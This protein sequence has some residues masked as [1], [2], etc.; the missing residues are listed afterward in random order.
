[1]F[2]PQWA[3]LTQLSLQSEIYRYH[4][5]EHYSSIRNID[6]PFEGPPEIN[7]R[8]IKQEP[9]RKLTNQDPP[10]SVERAIMKSTGVDDLAL[11]REL[12]EKYRGDVDSVYNEIYEKQYPEDANAEDGNT[13]RKEEAGVGDV[14]GLQ[15]KSSNQDNDSETPVLGDGKDVKIVSRKGTPIPSTSNNNNT[16]PVPSESTD[17]QKEAGS[18][19]DAE[20]ASAS[21]GVKGVIP[22]K[23]ISAREKKEAA[24]RNQ[25][26]NRKNKGKTNSSSGESNSSSDKLPST[27]SGGSDG[28]GAANTNTTSSTM[29]ELFV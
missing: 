7:P 24:K 21:E 1:M 25:K 8:P 16:D 11:V 14:E 13:E 27:L 20:P 2:K 9:L 18:P 3:L 23:R 5:W 4:S 19:E 28:K 12:M 10:R 15:G 17:S 29:R 6:G 26:L 22:K